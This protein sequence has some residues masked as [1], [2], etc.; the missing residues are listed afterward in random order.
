M[1]PLQ[2]YDEQKVI[3]WTRIDMLI[4]LYGKC[5]SQICAAADSS[6]SK[7]DARQSALKAVQILIQLRAGVDH[8]QGSLPQQMSRL[9][10]FAKHSLLDGTAKGVSAAHR[11]V[12]TLYEAFVDIREEAVELE[13]MGA[14]PELVNASDYERNA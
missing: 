10:E 9:L 11:I 8:E 4:A 6:A 1:N 14:I 2:T 13:T 3:N 12:S 7:V 5:L